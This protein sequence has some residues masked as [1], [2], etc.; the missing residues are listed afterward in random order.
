MQFDKDIFNYIE[1]H[2]TKPSEALNKIERLANIKLTRPRMISGALQGNLLKILVGIS[3]AKK[4][5]EIGTFAAYA[6]VAMA[7]ALPSSV[8]DEGPIS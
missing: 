3:G 4:V 8:K 6:S 7:E 1:E 5:L 2:S